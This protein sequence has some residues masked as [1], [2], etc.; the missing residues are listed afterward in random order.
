MVLILKYWYDFSE[1][2]ISD[3]LDITKSAVKSRLHRARQHMAE[4][5]NSEEND[6]SRKEGRQHEPQQY[7]KWILM[8]ITFTLRGK[9]HLL[10]N[11]RQAAVFAKN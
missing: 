7:E 3:A 8:I 4:Q 6:I 9:S 1:D 5:W 11:T 2:E 10:K